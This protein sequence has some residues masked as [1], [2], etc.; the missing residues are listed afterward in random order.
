MQLHLYCTRKSFPCYNK[1][2]LESVAKSLKLEYYK[3]SIKKGDN[4]VLMVDQED[5]LVAFGILGEKINEELSNRVDFELF[6]LY[7]S[8]QVQRKGLGKKLYW[9]LERRVLAQGGYGIGVISSLSAV[10]FYEACG[11]TL[12]VDESI[13]VFGKTRIPMKVLEKHLDYS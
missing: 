9:E 3:S 10:P 1:E 4:V 11:F 5:R 13:R 7:V 2:Q 6:K 8:P 12:T